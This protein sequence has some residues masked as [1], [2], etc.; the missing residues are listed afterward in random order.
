MNFFFSRI[1]DS[2]NSMYHGYFMDHYARTIER[3][4][5][6][7]KEERK[8]EQHCQFYQKKISNQTEQLNL[9]F[10]RNFGHFSINWA[11]CN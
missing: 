2:F 4:P 9:H 7:L 8:K 11:D 6:E 10:D 1:E 3:R 5:F